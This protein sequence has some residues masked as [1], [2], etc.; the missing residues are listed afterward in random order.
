TRTITWVVND[1]NASNATSTAQTTTVSLTA[2]NDPPTLSNV[3]SSASYTEDNAAVTLA[4]S[5]S[6]SDPDNLTL[7]SATG[8]ITG[9]TFAN[10]GD[11][12]AAVTT[13]TAITASYN[14]TTEALTLSGTDTLAHYQQVLDSVTFASGDNP[15]DYGSNPTRTIT[16]TLNDGAASNQLSATQ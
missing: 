5:A 8:A 9:G 11:V 10:E 4:G 1:G 12:L 13:G 2:V 14:S 6:G 15:D 16:W 3:A 7:A